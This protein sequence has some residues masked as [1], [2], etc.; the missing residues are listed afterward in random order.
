M[1]YYLIA[2]NSCVELLKRRFRNRSLLDY[3]RKENFDRIVEKGRWGEVYLG[4]TLERAYYN[5]FD[6]E[7]NFPG[8]SFIRAH[9]FKIPLNKYQTYFLARFMLQVN[10]RV[11][12]ADVKVSE[13]EKAGLLE[14]LS[15]GGKTFK[16]YN[17][18]GE[19]IVVFN[20]SFPGE[21]VSFPDNLQGERFTPHLYKERGCEDINRLINASS[22]IL[23]SHPINKVRE[24]LNEPSA[25]L[26]WL[27]GSGRYVEVPSFG[28]KTGKR[29]F[30]FSATGSSI[31]PAE[32]LGFERISSL[33][34]T[35]DNSFIW[36]NA[37]I[38]TKEGP[39][40]WL[41]HFESFDRDILKDVLEEYNGGKC[42]VV[43]IFDGFLSP[44][45]EI[46]NGRGIFLMLNG[47]PFSVFGL[48]KY[49]KNGRNFI[50][51]FLT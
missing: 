15:D 46:K 16:F 5:L 28:K 44:N 38:D 35:E 24:D 48:R 47:V 42:R 40:I 29:A 7:E 9:R 1:K 50:E 20:K 43:F 21:K 45:V 26:L 3:A 41:R 49:F 39:A 31:P 30:Y 22:G 8:E 25:N 12:E 51:K 32:L 13:K 36:I 6:G 14:S 10:G 11:M 19:I 34:E 27:W 33:S 17:R 18:E 37:S 4:Q 23:S 2:L